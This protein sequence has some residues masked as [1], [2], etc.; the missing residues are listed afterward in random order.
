MKQPGLKPVLRWYLRQ[1]LNFTC[2]GTGPFDLFFF[3]IFIFHDTRKLGGL[4]VT[5]TLVFMTDASEKQVNS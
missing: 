1:W 3:L 5:G 2:Y 4:I